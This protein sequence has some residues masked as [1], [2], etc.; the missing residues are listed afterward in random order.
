MTHK[1][2]ATFA[3]S[4]SRWHGQQRHRFWRGDSL[5]TCF[6]ILPNETQP[7]ESQLSVFNDLVC[8]DGDF[9]TH[10]AEA[11]FQYYYDEVYLLITHDGYYAPVEYLTP[12][13]NS[14]NEIWEL[15]DGPTILIEDQSD[16]ADNQR[17]FSLTFECRWDEDFG[18]EVF[19]SNWTV[20]RISKTADFGI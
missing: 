9:T 7:T 17:C 1:I 11:L 10:V 3:R 2:V 16:F 4:L 12:E 14:P 18:V 20:V 15:L 5:L 8:R 19:V 6:D 13:V